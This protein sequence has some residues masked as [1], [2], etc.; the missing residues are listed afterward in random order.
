MVGCAFMKKDVSLLIKQNKLQIYYLIVF[1]GY[2][3]LNLFGMQ[4]SKRIFYNPLLLFLS[5]GLAKP[6]DNVFY[7]SRFLFYK[8]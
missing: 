2:L 8:D 5:V 6:S 1:I 3:V 4:K 7:Q